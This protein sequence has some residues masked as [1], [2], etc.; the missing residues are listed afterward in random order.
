MFNNSD[1]HK[2]VTIWQKATIVPGY[3]ST[4]YRKDRHGWWIAYDEYG[5]LTTYGWEF[6]HIRP[7][8]LMGSDEVSNLQPLH[9]RA[10]RAKSNRLIG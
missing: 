4:R 6:D 3:D 8:S 9:W 1:E 10:N 2:K 5:Q 7:S